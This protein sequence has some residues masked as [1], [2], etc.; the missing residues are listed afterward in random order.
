LV[1][2]TESRADDQSNRLRP[3]GALVADAAIVLEAQSKQLSDSIAIK[4][5]EPL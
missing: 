4:V 2:V 1:V 5:R 3:P